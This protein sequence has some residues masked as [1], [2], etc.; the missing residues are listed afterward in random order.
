[1]R[2]AGLSTSEPLSGWASR[3]GSESTII[4]D[5]PAEAKVRVRNA[6]FIYAGTDENRRPA[7]R[8]SG[9][10]R[11]VFPASPLPHN[12]QEVY[13]REGLGP[14]VDAVYAFD[15]DQ[16]VELVKKGYFTKGYQTPSK[17]QDIDYE[18]PV[19]I[20]AIVLAPRNDEDVPVIFLDVQGRNT[21]ALTHASTGYDL[22]RYFEDALENGDPELENEDEAEKTGP[23]L[24]G[25]RNDKINDLFAGLDLDQAVKDEAAQQGPST[26]P[27]QAEV[28]ADSEFRRLAD[29]RL[30]ELDVE[31]ASD[32]SE[33]RETDPVELFHRERVESHL[34]ERP[35]A[36]SEPAA[37]TTE[38]SSDLFA[39]LDPN[40]ESIVVTPKGVEIEGEAEVTATRRRA[41]ESQQNTEIR[42]SPDRGRDAGE[43]GRPDQSL[44]D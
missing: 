37:E 27:V 2:I 38:G 7:V 23:A 21:L 16:L 30:R 3:A 24:A 14:S 9:E 1:M 10:L 29:A 35:E 40:D 17:I 36:E 44:G 13:F 22:V 19:Q 6:H 32:E 31:L 28:E 34:D 15:Q 26:A 42:Q 11:S 33:A 43:T 12:V 39:G 25:R 8:L 4:T 41:R 18:L 20:D 5:E